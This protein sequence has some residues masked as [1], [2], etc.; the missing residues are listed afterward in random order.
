[1]V[2][3][4]IFLTSEFRRKREKLSK[5][6]E[7]KCTKKMGATDQPHYNG[8]RVIRDSIITVFQ[9]NLNFCLMM[10]GPFCIYPRGRNKRQMREK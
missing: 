9:C 5:L 4:N 1:M 10:C 3:A 7:K 8:F 2:M 6:G